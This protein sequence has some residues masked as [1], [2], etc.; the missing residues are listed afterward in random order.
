[1]MD[2]RTALAHI[3]AGMAAA[4]PLRAWAEGTAPIPQR[5]PPSAL[6]DTSTLAP[7]TFLW[8]PE[9]SPDG[10]VVFIVSLPQQTVHVYRNGI[11]IGVSTCS[12]GKP[13][14]ETPTG[15]FLI[16]QKDKHHHSSTYN[17][18][19]MPNMQRLTWGGVALHAGHLP[20]YPASHGCVRLPRAFSEAIFGISHLGVP[21]I[22]A[23]TSSAPKDIVHP[24]FLLST[25]AQ[26]EAHEALA[27]GAGKPHH[28]A[29]ATTHNADHVAMV[30]SGADKVAIMM[31]DG[32]P[33]WQSGVTIVDPA[34]PLGN[35]VYKLMGV[36]ES[37]E[38][39]SWLAHK[40]HVD[41]AGGEP[42]PEVLARIGVDDWT[43]ALGV[44]SDMRPGSSLV[45]TDLSAGPETRTGADFVIMRDDDA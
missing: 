35:H 8:Q 33:I 21:V 13:G 44:L 39:L 41:R 40:I 28:G 9:L 7:G 5:A 1:M 22:V 30:V 20:G 31:R 26:K 25:E 16:L 6:V 36:N 38:G 14:H 23:D 11:E 12:T 17:N 2:R 3:G 15:V 45:V 37:G 29:D 19:P 27:A 43:G 42:A 24:G 10:P 34:R 4:L 18:A 32:E